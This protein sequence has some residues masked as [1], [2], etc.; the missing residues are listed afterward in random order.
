MTDEE[1]RNLSEERANIMSFIRRAELRVMDIDER[2]RVDPEGSNGDDFSGA[3][4]ALRKKG[5]L[6]KKD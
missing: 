5:A 6:P 2:L 1:R 4:E 3:V